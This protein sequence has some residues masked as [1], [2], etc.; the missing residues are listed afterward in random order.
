MPSFY[1]VAIFYAGVHRLV[2][3]TEQ[4]KCVKFILMLATFHIFGLFIRSLW[5]IDKIC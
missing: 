3:N 4:Q 1:L 2:Y 5:L